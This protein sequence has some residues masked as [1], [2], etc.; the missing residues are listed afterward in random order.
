MGGRRK[1]QRNI[2]SE[3]LHEAFSAWLRHGSAEEAGR[4]VGVNAS[5]V[6]SARS[7]SPQMWAE[8]VRDH[9]DAIRQRRQATAKD[10]A[11]GM[12]E[13]VLV[14]RQALR[15][16]AKIPGKDSAALLKALTAVDS[17]L[18]KIARLDA[19]T[20]TEIREDRRSDADVIGDI[21]R[22]LNDPA[23]RA[24]MERLQAEAGV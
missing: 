22:H 15:G 1:G 19:S 21:E 8:V 14:A 24:A 18:D 12:Q 7:R 23:L 9:V 16:A 5:S 11:E 20:P 3:R 10:A 4:L 17:S 13:A 6:R 2:P